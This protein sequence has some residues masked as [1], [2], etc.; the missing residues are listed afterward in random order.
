MIYIEPVQCAR[1]KE[2]PYLR[3]GIIEF[4]CAPLDVVARFIEFFPVETAETVG[5]PAE[6]GRYPVEYDPD[7]FLME[8]VDKIHEAL[9]IPVS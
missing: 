9:G 7:P 1:D 4:I 5:I 2:A 3:A 8:S 6:V